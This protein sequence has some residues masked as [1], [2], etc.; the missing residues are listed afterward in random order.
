M[1]A[2]QN[3]LVD[4]WWEWI[5]A[6]SWQ[7]AVFVALVAAV[8]WCARRASPQVRYVLW[9]LVL[10]KIFLPPSLAVNWGVGTWGLR[11]AWESLQSAVAEEAVVNRSQEQVASNHDVE[12]SAPPRAAHFEVK[13]RGILFLVWLA[14]FF[15][16]LVT[17]IWQYR[18]LLQ[19]THAMKSVDEGPLQFEYERLALKMSTAESPELFFSDEIASPFLF[20]FWK[21]KIVLPQSMVDGFSH[22]ELQNVLAHELNHWRRR[23]LWIGWVQVLAQSLM[24]FHPLVWWANSR[25]RHERECACDEGVL[26]LSETEPAAYGETLLRVLS[27]A[28]GRAVLQ[29]NLIGVFEPGGNIQQRLEQIMNY[30]FVS[31][32]FPILWYPALL[33]LM[34]LLV[35]MMPVSTAEEKV[36]EVADKPALQM[37]AWIV[38]TSPAIGA[39]DVDPALKEVSVTFDRDMSDGMSWTGGGP[40]FPGDQAK[41][42]FW[43]DKRV[44]VLPVMLEAGKFY[45]VGINSKS[46]QN[47]RSAKGEVVPHAAI[48]FVTKG[49]GVP[50]IV[51]MVPEN[52]ATDV[53]PATKALRITFNVPM[54]EG[55]SWVRTGG[56]FPEVPAG[57]T[58]K[59]S[60]NGKTCI[61]PVSLKGGQDYEVGIND[62]YHINFQS[63]RG[64]PFAPV[65]Y[66]FR[67]R[68]AK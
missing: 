24:W 64:V 54:G 34:L 40:E 53:D 30:K 61:L 38:E 35:P 59:W 50:K 6:L 47:F 58:P 17:S 4:R 62:V 26:Q 49:P 15:G 18:K 56:Q 16:L 22:E 21:P 44:C 48:Y 68:A 33:I 29:G 51:K 1:N 63:K 7:L 12:K 3:W 46:Y 66:K 42:A 14:G 57:K 27:A 60:S 10:V 41:K 37:P 52:G 45:R 11:P 43:R 36:A 20:G 65:A 19:S 67:T 31:N 39:V 28:R 55:M 23:D 13:P 5:V 32:R 25:L 2:A 9:S 8:T